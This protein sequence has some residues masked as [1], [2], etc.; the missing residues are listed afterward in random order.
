MS[1]PSHRH[2][3]VLPLLALSI[4]GTGLMANTSA[5]VHAV[6]TS[7][8]RGQELVTHASGLQ[9]L[10]GGGEQIGQTGDT[11]ELL[12]GSALV[13]SLVP[14]TLRAGVF[15]L[16]SLG[17]G[18]HVTRS[19]NG[20]TVAAVTTPVLVRKGALKAVVPIGAQWRS[21]GD[22][23]ALWGEGVEA[24]MQSRS[25]SALPERF[26]AEQRELL[27]SIPRE[28]DLPEIRTQI[29]A[30]PQAGP[31]ELPEAFERRTAE[32]VE[33][34]LGVFRGRIESNDALVV[35][36]LLLRPDL[37]DVFRSPKALDV[38]SALLFS[39]NHAAAMQQQLLPLLVRDPDLW[40]LLSLHPTV[41]TV[42]WTLV[43]PPHDGER[44][45]LRLW[46]FPLADIDDEAGN[47]AA[48]SRWSEELIAA[49][50]ASSDPSAT[51]NALIVRLGKVAELREEAGYPQRARLITEAIRE[52]SQVI[53]EVS[54]ESRE[55]ISRLL[56]LDR[57]DPA[58]PPVAPT[59]EQEA[60]KP[61]EEVAFD[62]LR[63]EAEAREILRAASAAFSL[64]TRVIPLNSHAALVEN[65]VFAGNGRDR[66]VDFTL[67]TV[68]GEISR[69]REK[70]EEYPYALPIEAFIEWIRK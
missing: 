50:K 10:V 64:E 41:S 59:V 66:T 22:S 23:L 55:T 33:A 7:V 32:W 47:A 29:P 9:A 18:Y 20:L 61:E 68:R 35:Q 8:L 58:E 54:E 51:G 57:I 49:V 24:W 12:E 38:A 4:L 25:V 62:P 56:R 69:I 36:E 21:G 63:V 31:V 52:L 28:A 11:P 30:H 48:W 44:A 60:P 67:D 27:Q 42:T 15:T 43:S 3:V 39:Q 40:L 65:I 34:V 13:T 6:S 46:M 17:G 53:P 26:L 45:A 5:G 2:T 19:S 16:R 1:H 37:Q 70:G 14:V